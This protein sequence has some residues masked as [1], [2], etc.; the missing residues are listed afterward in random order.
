MWRILREASDRQRSGA[1]ILPHS[2]ADQGPRE[3]ASF[4]SRMALIRAPAT[5]DT[6]LLG[7][8]C[9]RE[10]LIPSGARQ[11]RKAPRYAARYS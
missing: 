1:P 2:A 9:R 4:H 10:Y 11:S 6:E 8:T 3:R 7:T 5:T